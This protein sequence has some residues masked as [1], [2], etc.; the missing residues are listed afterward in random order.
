M[1]MIK[2]LYD[3]LNACLCVCD[4][5]IEER[6]QGQPSLMPAQEAKK[7]ICALQTFCLIRH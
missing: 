3:G 2:L 6:S 5:E 1:V 7:N 4:K